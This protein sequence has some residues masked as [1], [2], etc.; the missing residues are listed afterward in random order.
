ME[1][2][3]TVPENLGQR[4]SEMP[5]RVPEILRIGLE[6]LDAG[7]AESY[8]GVAEILDKLA[9]LPSPDEVIALRP[10]NDLQNRI[11]SLLEKNRDPGLTSDE[12]KEWQNYEHL[13]HV[14]RMAK[15]RANAMLAKS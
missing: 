4:V 2:T 3:I 15:A 5:D 13:E 8:D 14:V 11:E 12:E 10:S 9:Q 7:D 6:K 1:L